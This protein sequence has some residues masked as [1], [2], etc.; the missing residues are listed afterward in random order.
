MSNVKVSKVKGSMLVTFVKAIKADKTG[1]CAK[2]L[3][4]QDKEVVST[5]ILA[6]KWYPF[7]VYK[8]CFK[9]VCKVN[10]GNRADVLR[11]WGRF[12][13]EETMTNIYKTVLNKKDAQ[14]ALDTFRQITKNVYDSINIES[15]MVSDN[16]VLIKITD[17]DPDFEQ[18]YLVGLGWIERTIELVI[19][20]EVKSKIME[21]SWLGSP[22]TV[23]KMS[24][25]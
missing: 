10:A 11:E 20:K 9:A 15:T 4:D 13:G 18:W 1:A 19:K 8:N 6:S 17:F 23:Y 2:L 7:E 3:T 25:A 22:A 21:R 16:E 24:W 5:L 14:S 12:A